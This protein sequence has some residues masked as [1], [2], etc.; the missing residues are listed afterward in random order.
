MAPRVGLQ[1][2]HDRVLILVV[3][4]AEP[5]LHPHSAAELAQDLDAELVDRG[6]FDERRFIADLVQ[7]ISDLF[8]GFVGEREGADALGRDSLF[9]D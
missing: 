8:G 4:D 3:R 6:A 5:L 9:L 7:A 2:P 1:T